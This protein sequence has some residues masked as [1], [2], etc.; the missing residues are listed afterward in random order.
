VS[1]PDSYGVFLLSRIVAMASG[2]LVAAYFLASLPSW[3]YDGPKLLFFGL[4]TLL[5]A[6]SIGHHSA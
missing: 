5:N 1:H 3:D 2:C 4:L 6:R